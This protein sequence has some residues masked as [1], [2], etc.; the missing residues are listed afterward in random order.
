VWV[1]SYTKLA[2]ACQRRH[3]AKHAPDWKLQRLEP[4]V[5]R[6]T[7]PSGRTYTT[8][9]TQYEEWAGGVS[10]WQDVYSAHPSG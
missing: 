4:G 1:V 8:H 3:H 10:N 5:I 7:T 6:W 2:P 9:L